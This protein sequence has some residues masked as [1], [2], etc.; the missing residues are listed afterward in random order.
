MLRRMASAARPIL[1][2]IM[3]ETI[4]EILGEPESWANCVSDELDG[5]ANLRES[6]IVDVFVSRN[7]L[8]LYALGKNGVEAV[9]VFVIEDQD[10]R[11][12]IA[13]AILPGAD[14]L[15]TLRLAI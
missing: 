12:K 1:G 11:Q 10:L 4:S 15:A 5:L 9:A 3:S 13:K 2:D 7:E 6:T 14:V 8:T